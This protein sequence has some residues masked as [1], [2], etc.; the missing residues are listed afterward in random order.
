[1]LNYLWSERNALHSSIGGVFAVWQPLCLH[2]LI[3]F[4]HQ[5]DGEGAIVFPIPEMRK[6]IFPE[7]QSSVQ[8]RSHQTSACP[9]SESDSHWPLAPHRHIYHTVTTGCLCTKP[10]PTSAVQTPGQ[11]TDTFSNSLW[12]KLFSLVTY[13]F[14]VHMFTSIWDAS[15]CHL[16]TPLHPHSSHTIG[17][18]SMDLFQTSSPPSSSLCWVLGQLGSSIGFP[19]LYLNSSHYLLS[20]RLLWSI[21]PL[22]C[23]FLTLG[24]HCYRM[25]YV[26][27]T[28][29]M[30]NS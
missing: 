2:Y 15:C 27:C 18:S 5:P 14:P 28:I 13:Y 17:F 9:A 7:V 24:T 25:N 3:S 23:V 19:R 8:P 12:K 29:H 1:M 26:P 10:A 16:P 22:N 6:Q 30:L 21:S 20:W 11:S 4:S